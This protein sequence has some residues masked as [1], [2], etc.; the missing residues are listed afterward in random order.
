M[1]YGIYSHVAAPLY[2]NVLASECILG[3]SLMHYQ[4][5]VNVFARRNND[6]LF[7]E[8]KYALT[9]MCPFCHLVHY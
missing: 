8:L 1:Q 4:T 3:V 7:V 6:I 9:A 2:S 5:E